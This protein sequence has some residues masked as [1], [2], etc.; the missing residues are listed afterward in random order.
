MAHHRST[1]AAFQPFRALGLVSN[2]VPFA[3]QHLGGAAGAVGGGTGS[4]GGDHFVTTCVGRGFHVYNCDRLRLVMASDQ[5]PHGAPAPSSA[6][7]LRR[8]ARGQRRR[9][10][11]GGAGGAAAGGASSRSLVERQQQRDLA[12]QVD[13]D[14]D[15]AEDQDQREDG[16]EDE[17]EDH[18]M[19]IDSED[20]EQEDQDEDEEDEEDADAAAALIIRCIASHRSTTITTLGNE[21]IIW[22]RGKIVQ[23]VGHLHP[24]R[25][26]VAGARTLNEIHSMVLLGDLVVTCCDG[27]LLKAWSLSTLEVLSELELPSQSFHVSAVVHPSTYLNKLLL[28]SRQGGLQLWNIRTQTLVYSFK[29]WGSPVTYLAQSPAVDV[30]AIGLENASIVLHNLKT[31]AVLMRFTQDGPVTC[32]SFRTGNVPIMSSCGTDGNIALWDLEHRRLANIVKD[33]HESAIARAEFL[34]SQPILLSAGADNSVKMWIFDQTDGS[35]RL[36]RSREGHSAPPTR[37]RFYGSPGTATAGHLLLSAGLDR[38]LRLFSTIAD[39]QSTELSQGHLKSKTARFNVKI[40]S[41]RFPPI[42]DFA[43]EDARQRD[44]DNVATCHLGSSVIHTWR[45]ETKSVGKHAIKPSV[46]GATVQCITVSACGNF[47]LAGL[48]AGVVDIH[49]IQSGLHRGTLGAKGSPHD[50]TVTGV[51]IDAVNEVVV[52]CGLDGF[53]KFWNFQN[54]R[55]IASHELD[56]PLTQLVLHRESGMVAVVGDDF[57]V[58]LF[59]VDS[60]KLVRL[61]AGHAARITDLTFKTDGRWLAPSSM[62]TTIRIWELPTGCLVEC[63]SAKMPPPAANRTLFSTVSLRAIAP[64]QPL[65]AMPLPVSGEEQ[66]V[67]ADAEDSSA[68][69]LNAEDGSFKSADQLSA[70]LITMSALPKARWFNLTNLDL[71]RERNKPKEAPKAPVAAPFFLP[72]IAGTED[73]FAIR[74]ESDGDENNRSTSQSRILNFADMDVLSPFARLL[75]NCGETDDFEPALALLIEF[76]PVAVDLE[77]RGLYSGSDA[78]VSGL[79]NRAGDVTLL[80]Q[81]GK[82]LVHGLRKRTH[83][84]L[85]QAFLNVFLKVH[86]E[87]F[88]NQELLRPLARELQSAVESTWTDFQDSFQHSLCMIQFMK[89][90]SL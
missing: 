54:R 1:S 30:V 20:D 27:N 2:H 47:I 86:E 60:R 28:G 45:T 88:A 78:I 18:E 51:A 33:A 16:D 58:R 52:T 13:E 85:L 5:I 43:A 42:V 4:A 36:L 73:K 7:G 76:P 12:D 59:D 17:G 68:A 23:R 15:Q 77:I 66:L 74:L 75:L 14:E 8:R 44:W 87:A 72:T 24:R 11:A 63:S 61:F 84:E 39:A 26:T 10:A 32:I 82:M 50:G 41:L 67:S 49:N 80:Q 53:V 38:T 22:Q 89:N 21:V 6:A 35:A 57:S 9:R 40:E 71:I 3:V 29:G 83:F 46:Q 81:F 25:V 70:E 69:Y 55:L 31:D 64:D 34:Q 56:V 62:E 37:V 48:S 65:T 79:S 19:D 90:A